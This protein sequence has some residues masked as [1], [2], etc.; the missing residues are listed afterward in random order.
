ML[1]M[2]FGS[3]KLATERPAFVMGI[4]NVTDDSFYPGSRG[5]VERAMAL[6]EQGADIIDI[7]GESTRPG[8][9]EVDEAEELRRVIPVVRAVRKNSD[10]VISVD[11]RK[12]GVMEA[13]AGEGADILNDVSSLEFDIRSVSVA[14]ESGC[15]VVLMHH[16][17]GTVSAVASFSQFI[18]PLTMFTNAPTGAKMSSPAALFIVPLFCMFNVLPL[19]SVSLA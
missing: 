4:V 12:S 16:E 15:S 18:F 10:A 5:G 17:A 7:G 2:T 8:F 9:T 14:A 3:R 11:T 6:I 19:L 1:K 13:A